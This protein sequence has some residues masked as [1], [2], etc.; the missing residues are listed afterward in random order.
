ME[1]EINKFRILL[2]ED[3][4]N[5]YYN[6]K[7]AI[8]KALIDLNVANKAQPILNEYE[9]EFELIRLYNNYLKKKSKFSELPEKIIEII[10]NDILPEEGDVIYFIDINWNNENGNKNGFE[11]IKECLNVVNKKNII[12]LT[13]YTLMAEHDSYKYLHKG[14]INDEFIVKI[15]HCITLT[16]VFD[17]L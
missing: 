1:N 7:N 2:L 10:N 14:P 9:K 11:F 6:Y 17:R 5:E 8:N 3:N 4:E 16:D 12:L 15:R 13:N